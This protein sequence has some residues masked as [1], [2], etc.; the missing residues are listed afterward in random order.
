MSGRGSAWI[1][2][3]SSATLSLAAASLLLA[4]GAGA[5]QSSRPV[6][7]HAAT[8][9]NVH[10]EG[11]LHFVHASGSV[12]LDEG[13]VSGTFPGSA[14]VHFLYNGEPEVSAQFTID[15]HG[16]SVSARATARL[17]SPTS[18]APSFRGR[19]TITAGTGRYA[20]VHGGGELYG[21]YNRRSY[22]LS[23]QA[24]AKLPY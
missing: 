15:G 17:S 6:D 10:D 8:T 11:H 4:S 3:V 22:A 18:A 21:V 7:A 13:S 23:V 16:G 9:L 20:H 19:M 1:A 24:I 14:R 5:G 2:G 12:I